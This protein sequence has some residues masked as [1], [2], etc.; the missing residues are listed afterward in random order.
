MTT[1]TF[2][3][4]EVPLQPADRAMTAKPNRRETGGNLVG[5]AVKF[6]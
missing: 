3:S 2:D 1:S 6:Q 5:F 4:A